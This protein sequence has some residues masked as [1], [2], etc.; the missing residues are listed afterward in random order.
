MPPELQ[1][2]FLSLSRPQQAFVLS[3]PSAERDLY[4]QPAPDRR[5]GGTGRV[6]AADDLKALRAH[7]EAKEEEASACRLAARFMRAVAKGVNRK[8]QSEY[9]RLLNAAREAEEDRVRQI[10]MRRDA[11]QTRLE[12]QLAQVTAM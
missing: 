4:L 3:L 11:A 5:G 9:L 7:L 12:G 6:V 1:R 8:Q 2:R 10:H